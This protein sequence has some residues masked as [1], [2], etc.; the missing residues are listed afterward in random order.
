MRDCEAGRRLLEYVGANIPDVERTINMTLGE[1]KEVRN[2]AAQKGVEMTIDE[3][4]EYISI[5]SEAYL[6]VSGV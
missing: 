1:I 4:E 3:I 2:F 5:L 6:I